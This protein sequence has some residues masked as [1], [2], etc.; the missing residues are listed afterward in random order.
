MKKSFI[1]LI[2]IF[3]VVLITS[4]PEVGQDPAPDPETYTITYNG[5]GNDIGMAPVDGDVYTAGTDV[6]A[7]GA[8]TMIRT[9]FTFTGWNTASAGSGTDYAAGS[10]FTMGTSS[11][12]LFARWIHSSLVALEKREMVSV[13]GGTFN[14]KATSGTPDNFDHTISDFQLGKYEVSYELWDT[15]H[16]WALAN[17]Y[18]F[19][20]PGQEG[21]DGTITGPAGEPPTTAMYEPV[22]NISSRDS[23]VWCNAYSEM[24]TFT[25]CYTYNNALIK[26]SRDAN[27]TACDEAVCN[28][29]A[30]GFRL[31]GEGEWQYAAS[32]KGNI[33]Y[34]YASGATSDYTN[35]VE[36]QKVAWYGA[37]ASGSTHDVGTTTASSAQS[38]WDISGNVQEWCWDL[39]GD[40]PDEPQTDYRC[41][42]VS[43]GRIAR[44]GKWTNGASDTQVGYRSAAI[45]SFA[46]Q[47]LGFRVARYK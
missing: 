42:S 32:D 10:A 15:V 34:N 31:P 21:H 28:W 36:T 7:A 46:T 17:G 13:I 14:Q 41:S 9:N 29:S 3:T 5:N 1:I 27:A 4:C 43:A 16:S 37:N 25:P 11:M 30:N 44:G 18:F 24:A 40:Y 47:V 45:F 23:I 22:T 39:Y 6:T 19:A 2:T 38:L 33:P 26:D 8:G 12:T 35:D 20:N